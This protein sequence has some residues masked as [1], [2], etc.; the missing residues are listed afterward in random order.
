MDGLL[1]WR[2]LRSERPDSQSHG[3]NAPFTRAALCTRQRRATRPEPRQEVGG[4]PLMPSSFTF[5]HWN[6]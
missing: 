4:S 5:S 3:S 6:E 1:F 2:R